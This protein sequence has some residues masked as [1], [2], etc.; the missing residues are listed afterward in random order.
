VQE[1]LRAMFNADLNQVA[2][3]IETDSNSYLFRVVEKIPSQIPPLSDIRDQVVAAARRD[4]AEKKAKEEAAALLTKLQAGEDL[5]AVAAAQNL[6]VQE[7]DTFRRLDTVIPGLGSQADLRT[8]AFKLTAAKPIAGQ[9]YDVEGDAVVAVL[10]E[11]QPADE[12]HFADQKESLRTQLEERR[13]RMVVDEY[14]KE[15][16][17]RSLIHI[18][19]EAVDRVYLS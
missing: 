16:K 4:L 6:S 2:E 5:A 3:P 13:K 1:L 10:K 12:S 9:V 18:N 8:D 15:L 7:T 14:I 19:P 17:Q 11:K